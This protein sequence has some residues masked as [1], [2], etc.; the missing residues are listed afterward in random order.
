[1]PS[2]VSSLLVGWLALALAAGGAGA[3]TP[4]ATGDGEG[5]SSGAT[6][7]SETSH[8]LSAAERATMAE[9][10]KG[11]PQPGEP[12]PDVAGRTLDGASV[13]NAS[14]RGKTVVLN[15]WFYH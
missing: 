11:L 10:S 13:S 3:C 1:M 14:L 15:L 8:E 9:L 12:L 4:S 2:P 5:E 6:A 7:E